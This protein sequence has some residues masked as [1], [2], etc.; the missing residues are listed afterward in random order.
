MFAPACYPP[1]KPEAFVNSNLA[2]AMLDAGWSVDVITRPD[3]SL[4]YPSNVN[5]YER[6]AEHMVSIPEIEA[7]LVN[8]YIQVLKTAV[9]SGH[10]ASGWQWALPAAAAALK[11]IKHKKFD[12]IISRALPQS[13]HFAA[14]ITAKNTGIPWIANWNDPVPWEKFPV[15]FAGGRGPNAHLDYKT[16]RFFK[17]VSMKADWHTFPCER[18]RTYVADYLPVD[19]GLKSSV[20]PHIAMQSNEISSERNIKFKLLYAGSLISPRSPDIFL[21]GV[22]LFCERYKTRD[23]EI[24]FIVDSYEEVLKSAEKYGVIDLVKIEPSRPYAEMNSILNTADVL[25]II[26]AIMHEGI[27]LPSKFVDYVQTGKPILALSPVSGTLSDILNGV[28]GGLTV[29][30]SSADDISEGILKLYQHWSKGTLN[31]MFGSNRLLKTFSTETILSQYLQ[32]FNNI[33]KGG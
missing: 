14:L 30:N 1:G 29:D 11:H 4:W 12:F 21:K 26:E 32:V 25:V 24:V 16:S 5:I 2:L 33:T 19:I 17:A 8:K 31:N 10:I 22:S 20:I 6:L 7:T 3:S 27:F 18:L 9:M 13:A 15:E 23:L 28:G